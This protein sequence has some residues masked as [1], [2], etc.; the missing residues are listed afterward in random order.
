MGRSFLYLASKLGR[1]KALQIR[2]QKGG[3]VGA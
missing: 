3:A 2:F 1:Y